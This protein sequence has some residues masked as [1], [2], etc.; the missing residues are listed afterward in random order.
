MKL[1]H[2][3]SK[4]LYDN[5]IKT[6]GLKPIYDPSKKNYPE[7]LDLIYFTSDIYDAIE[8]GVE[9]YEMLI[10]TDWIV[11]EVDSEIVTKYCKHLVNYYYRLGSNEYIAS[12]KYGIERAVKEGGAI[13]WY[14]ESPEV[15]SKFGCVIPP[16]Y[17]KIVWESSR[18]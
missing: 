7:C 2:V 3:T 16:K 8:F 17:I 14:P 9:T 11:I 18:T 10:Q 13:S 6:E 12:S 4:D 15:K 1:Y 5:I